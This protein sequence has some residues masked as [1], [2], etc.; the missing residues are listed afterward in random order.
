L[1]GAFTEDRDSAIRGVLGQKPH[2]IPVHISIHSPSGDR[3]LNVEILDLPS[4]TAQAMMVSLY[5][6]LL[7]SNQSSDETSYHVTGSIGLAA[8]PDSPINEWASASD[9]GSPPL[10]LAVLVATRFNRIY[11]NG[12]RQGAVRSID[13]NVE[14]IPR[15]VQ[16]QLDTARI[17]SGDIVHGGDTVM[18][19][20]TIR[21]WQQQP[22]NVRIPVKLPERLNGGNL[23]ILVCDAG[24]LDRTLDQPRF[25]ARPADLET[26]LAQARARHA[27]DRIYVSLLVPETQAGVGGQA[28]TSLPLSVANALEPLRSAQDVNLNGETAA[29]AGSAPA[30]GVLSGFQ[31]LNLRIE[32]GGSLN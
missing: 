3:K 15:R 11:S 21:P 6:G 25:S 19:E 4:L 5:Q 29:E 2:M 22:R 18:V 32:Q 10:E 31:I 28:L 9:S 8:H 30:G 26:V 17:V 12:A 13:L 20:A 23:R 14:A 7:Q 16:V 27:A 24:T 1:I